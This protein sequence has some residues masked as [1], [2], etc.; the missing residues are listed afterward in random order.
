MNKYI[1]Y[2]HHN[3]QVMVRADL[4]GKHKDYCLCFKCNKFKPEDKNKNC[5]IA[6]LL[7]SVDS[8]FNIITPVWECPEFTQK[9]NDANS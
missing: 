6:S 7:C 1:R 9:I 3:R 4:K 2:E 8:I 5:K